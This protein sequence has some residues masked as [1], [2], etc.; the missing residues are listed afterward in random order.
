MKTHKIT[1]EQP[2]KSCICIWFCSVQLVYKEASFLVSQTTI[3][4]SSGL[5]TKSAR[6]FQ[7]E[8]NSQS[9]CH[10]SGSYSS[11]GRWS[12]PSNRQQRSESP[13]ALPWSL[14]LFSKRR[15]ELLARDWEI[16][17]QNLSSLQPTSRTR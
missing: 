6:L 13:F 10:P 15:T 16:S 4:L 1:T 12:L 2:C 9:L 17:S 3:S 7:D 5:Y 8:S 11:L 14:S